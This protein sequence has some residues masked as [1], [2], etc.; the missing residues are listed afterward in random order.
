MRTTLLLCALGLA[1]GCEDDLA[2]IAITVRQSDP[3]IPIIE[4]ETREILRDGTFLSSTTWQPDPIEFPSRSSTAFSG[5][6]IEFYTPFRVC[7]IGRSELGRDGGEDLVAGISG[8]VT[9]VLGQVVEVTLTMS[10]LE[11]EPL[12]AD[13]ELSPIALASPL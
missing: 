3:A 11:G 7:A 4:L 12:P 13:C 6:Q 9:P 1:A 8:G 5:D 2:T 10:P